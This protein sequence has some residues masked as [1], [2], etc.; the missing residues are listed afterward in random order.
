MNPNDVGGREF[1]PIPDYPQSGDLVH[2]LI[3]PE[4]SVFSKANLSQDTFIWVEFHPG[5]ELKIT[6]DTYNNLTN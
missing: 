3:K 5:T 2:L 6:D 1:A 4:K